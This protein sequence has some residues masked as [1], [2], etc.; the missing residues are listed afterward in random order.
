L[1]KR[2]IQT[3]KVEPETST[4]DMHLQKRAQENG[5]LQSI[6]CVHTGE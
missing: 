5:V 4:F 6:F 2:I 3:L 1:G